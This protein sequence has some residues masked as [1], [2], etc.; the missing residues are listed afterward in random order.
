MSIFQLAGLQA[1]DIIKI[2]SW[3]R[4]WEEKNLSHFKKAGMKIKI[5]QDESE[6][7][8]GKS[9]NK[10]SLQDR[11]YMIPSPNVMEIKWNIT[12]NIPPGPWSTLSY[13]IIPTSLIATTA[14][15][16][17]TGSFA[18]TTDILTDNECSV[19]AVL[20]R[21]NSIARK[22]KKQVP[23]EGGKGSASVSLWS[24]HFGWRTVSF[25]FLSL[26]VHTFPK[27]RSLTFMAIKKW[28][29]R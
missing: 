4:L 23:H 1:Y 16:T 6:D 8:S 28:I 14:L 13:E 24:W 20:P 17:Y 25:P 11:V 15:T 3:R 29:G 7:N 10:F 9:T 18:F 22:F 2:H 19:M 21:R 12:I 5:N 26:A 27:N